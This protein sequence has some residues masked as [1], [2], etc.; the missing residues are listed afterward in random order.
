MTTLREQL[1]PH[2][3]YVT[4][5]VD[6]SPI[7]MIAAEADLDITSLIQSKG[8][9]SL[10]HVQAEG[11]PGG[12]LSTP[13]ELNLIFGHDLEAGINLRAAALMQRV[14]GFTF[15]LTGDVLFVQPPIDDLVSVLKLET[16]AASEVS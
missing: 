3:H 15:N 8:R 12:G 11:E 16:S 5:P 2:A 4:I 14:V 10:C 13:N 9:L 7:Q 1:A 6:G